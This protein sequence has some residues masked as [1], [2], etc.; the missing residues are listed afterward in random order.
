MRTTGAFYDARGGSR[1]S[2]LDAAKGIVRWV[3]GSLLF[4]GAIVLVMVR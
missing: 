4:F 3:V 1:I 2:D